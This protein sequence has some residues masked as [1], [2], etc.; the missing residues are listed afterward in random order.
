[1]NIYFL[2]RSS[3]SHD[4]SNFLFLRSSPIASSRNVIFVLSFSQ[5]N[6]FNQSEYY[7]DDYK[8]LLPSAS[9]YFLLCS[10]YLRR[11]GLFVFMIFTFLLSLL[12]LFKLVLIHPSPSWLYHRF[13]F[14]SIFLPRFNSILVGDG[15]GSESLSPTPFWL[16][17]IYSGQRSSLVTSSYF[18]FS[19][20]STLSFTKYTSLSI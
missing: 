16:S 19:L 20:E 15:V 12:R 17:H 14:L 6:F 8:C 18:V 3:F 10:S 5:D 9:F 2:T 13:G 1:M 11:L 4:L 7:K